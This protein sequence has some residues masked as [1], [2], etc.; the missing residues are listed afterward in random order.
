MADRGG[1]LLNLVLKK[2]IAQTGKIFF[3]DA[4]NGFFSRDCVF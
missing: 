3:D 2:E 1:K 4:E